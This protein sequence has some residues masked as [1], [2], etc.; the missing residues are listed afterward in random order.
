MK[1]GEQVRETARCSRY[2][3]TLGRGRGV[4]GGGGGGALDPGFPWASVGFLGFP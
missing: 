3:A 2:K 4:G 1:L